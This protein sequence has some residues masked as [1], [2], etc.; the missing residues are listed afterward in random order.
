MTP[1]T[2]IR[3]EF[4][5][6]MNELCDE[7]DI[8]PGHGR[9]AALGRRFNVTSK[10]A[11]K[12]LLGLSYPE[13]AKAVEMCAA[14]R[15]NVLWLLQGTPPKSGTQIDP[16][17]LDLAEAIAGMPDAG[18]NAVLEFARFKVQETGSWYRPE[19]LR[20]YLRAID[21]LRARAAATPGDK[22]TRT[23]S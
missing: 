20:N 1:V 6:R 4:A 11:R 16:N 8:T 12:W 21:S 18:R 9:Q 22:Q 2:E 10:A 5:T 15:V 13:M 3:A 14:A 19:A 17:L 23:A 7:L